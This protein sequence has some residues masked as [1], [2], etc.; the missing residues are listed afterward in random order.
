MGARPIEHGRKVGTKAK[1]ILP[2]LSTVTANIP[3][4]ALFPLHLQ[5]IKKKI[6]K[7]SGL[8]EFHS[9]WKKKVKLFHKRARSPHYNPRGIPFSKRKIQEHGCP[10]LLANKGLL[11]SKVKTQRIGVE[12]KK[13][14]L[15]T[16]NGQTADP[17]RPKLV[18]PFFLSQRSC[19]CFAKAWG[20]GAVLSSSW[21]KRASE[22]ELKI[23]QALVCMRSTRT[24][25]LNQVCSVFVER[26]I[27]VKYSSGSNNNRSW[28]H[29]HKDL[30][31][32]SASVLIDNVSDHL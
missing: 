23:L 8:R 17:R 29:W 19:S 11:Q 18:Q 4:K 24:N 31:W 1:Q 14:Q 13:S 9:H 15:Q 20:R 25:V 28:L 16:T 12:K 27:G 7:K 2:M 22:R 5:L 3:H 32:E 21:P 10:S 30:I 26:V 6:K